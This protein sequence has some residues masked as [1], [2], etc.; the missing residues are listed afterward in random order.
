MAARVREPRCPHCSCGAGG[1]HFGVR[2][3]LHLFYEDCA[4]SETELKR[5]SLSWSSLLW[6]ACLTAGVLLA[7]TGGLALGMGLLL[8]PRIEGFG[9]GDLLL[10]DERAVWHNRALAAC[11]WAGGLLLA[12]GGT[13]LLACALAARTRPDSRARPGGLAP[14]ATA[15]ACVSP[16]RPGLWPTGSVQ[17][18]PRP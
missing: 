15:I 13:A 12:L 3:H 11:R 9:E 5:A 6:K 7:A 2:S 17:P 18:T 10:V 4:F 16:V 1:Q 14:R 8:P